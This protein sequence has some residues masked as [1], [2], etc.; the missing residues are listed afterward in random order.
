MAKAVFPEQKYVELGI[1]VFNPGQ[2]F[3]YLNQ[4]L[5][6]RYV[7]K[8]NKSH[9]KLKFSILLNSRKKTIILKVTIFIKK[10]CMK[11]IEI[12]CSILL[13]SRKKDNFLKSYNISK[14]GV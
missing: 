10:R 8:S 9:A 1:T 4:N 14:N 7:K 11:K 2:F 3:A 6:K 13:N 5:L 12:L